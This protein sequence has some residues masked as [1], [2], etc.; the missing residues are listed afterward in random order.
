MNPHNLADELLQRNIIRDSRIYQA[1]C[2]I[3][4]SEFVLPKYKFLAYTDEVLPSGEKN[5]LIISTSTQP[6][7]VVQMIQALNLTGDEK[8]LDIGT[9]TGY[10]TLILARI[11]KDGEVVSIEYD[12]ELHKI[13]QRNFKRY[14]AENITCINGDGFEG[15]EIKA[16]YDA[17]IS[18]V[19]CETLPVQWVAQLKTQPEGSSFPLLSAVFIHLFISSQE[20]ESEYT[21]I[22]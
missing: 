18:M 22:N 12:R 21:L 1:M 20:Q 3:D 5:G 14:G 6:S 15:Y 17:I 2:E 11:L 10:A 13:A 8:V 4:R 16:P 19:A 9:G 7:L